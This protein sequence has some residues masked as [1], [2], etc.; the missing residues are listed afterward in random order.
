MNVITVEF[1]RYNVAISSKDDRLFMK[2]LNFHYG[3]FDE[4]HMLKNMLSIRYKYL[5]NFKVRLACKNDDIDVDNNRCFVAFRSSG[6][7]S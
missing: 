1:P 6:S 4:A 3:V 5:S 7:C 2:K